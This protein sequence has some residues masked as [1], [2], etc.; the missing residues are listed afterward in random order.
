MDTHA[1][2]TRRAF[3]AGG[4]IA[5]HWA[6]MAAGV[7]LMLVGLAWASRWFCCRWACPWAW[8]GCC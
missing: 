4:R 8:P 5:G 2:P 3:Q 6:A 7:I 1:S